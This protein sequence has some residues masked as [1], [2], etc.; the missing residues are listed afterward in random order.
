M[1]RVITISLAI[2]LFGCTDDS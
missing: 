2:L 1:Y